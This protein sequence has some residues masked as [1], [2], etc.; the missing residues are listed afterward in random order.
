MPLVIYYHIHLYLAL[1]VKQTIVSHSS[2]NN[3]VTKLQEQ[4]KHNLKFSK[5]SHAISLVAIAYLISEI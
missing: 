4:I 3:F 1:I 5:Y 2:I